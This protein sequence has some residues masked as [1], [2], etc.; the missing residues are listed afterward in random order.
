MMREPNPELVPFGLRLREERKR[1][2]LT[3]AA[4][5][6]IGGVSKP[7]QISYE[8]GLTEFG[9]NYL[10]RLG[11][12]GVNIEFLLHGWE[13]AHAHATSIE[14]ASASLIN[15]EAQA[16]LRADT[17]RSKRHPT[18]EDALTQ[19]QAE[20]TKHSNRNRSLATEVIGAIRVLLD[21]SG[22][23]LSLKRMGMLESALYHRFE[24]T[25]R[26]DP[27]IAERIF[28]L[29]PEYHGERSSFDDEEEEATSAP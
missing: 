4:I 19:L 2:G 26:V 28:Q 29:M 11:D 16:R 15:A 10:R 8:Q 3:Q 24:R 14:T 21:R 5:A 17:E 23:A 22:I 6:S 1:L 7:T 9:V 13:P 27:A 20:I 18:T 25:R 12:A